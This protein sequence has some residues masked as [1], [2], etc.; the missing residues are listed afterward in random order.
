[1]GDRVIRRGLA[2]GILGLFIPLALGNRVRGGVLGPDPEESLP[3]TM[4][5]D[6]GTGA[7]VLAGVAVLIWAHGELE[8]GGS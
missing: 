7:A 2:R 6:W 5:K 3:E 8:Q 4:L 1:M